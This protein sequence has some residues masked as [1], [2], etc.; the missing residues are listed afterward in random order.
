MR[1][2]S[3]CLLLTE[4]GDQPIDG[5]Y[6]LVVSGVRDDPA[7]GVEYGHLNLTRAEL[8]RIMDPSIDKIMSLA[9]RQIQNVEKAGL[10]VTV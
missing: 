3:K 7:I 2:H 5:I 9:G 4:F 8:K 6:Y 1:K 10:H